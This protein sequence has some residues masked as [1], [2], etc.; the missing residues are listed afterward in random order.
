[1]PQARPAYPANISLA[2][3]PEAPPVTFPVAEAPLPPVV[4]FPSG[5]G[6]PTK[7]VGL[8]VTVPFAAMMA[9]LDSP[10][11][12][13]PPVAV[14]APADVLYARPPKPSSLTAATLG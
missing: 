13:A 2:N 4:P 1:M 11:T 14:D 5:P 6:L 10:M 9:G 3:N 12:A 7:M 8:G